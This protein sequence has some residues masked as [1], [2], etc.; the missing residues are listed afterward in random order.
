MAAPQTPR[1]EQNGGAAA[2][3]SEAFSPIL[4]EYTLISEMYVWVFDRLRWPLHAALE[5]VACAAPT[6]NP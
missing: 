4:N 3:P 5:S 6:P 2:I 1:A